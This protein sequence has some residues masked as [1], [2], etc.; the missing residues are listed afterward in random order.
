MS[1][2]EE[3]RREKLVQIKRYIRFPLMTH[4]EFTN[5]VL[6]KSILN[7]EEQH[8]MMRHFNDEES[9]QLK[10]RFLL[11]AGG[12]VA[13]LTWNWIH[14]ILLSRISEPKFNYTSRSR[15]RVSLIPRQGGGGQ[16]D[17]VGEN[18]MP[19]P[20]NNV[21]VAVEEDDS[22]KQ[23]FHSGDHCGICGIQYSTGKTRKLTEYC[24]HSKCWFCTSHRETGG[25][26]LCGNSRRYVVM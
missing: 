5:E 19:L 12:L 26:S 23:E 21:S 1:V 9:G 22:K 18:R 8:G 13:D 17:Q 2:N 20:M 11:F 15:T 6:Q 3:T 4:E 25:C 7:E 10:N 16:A 24:G 14:N